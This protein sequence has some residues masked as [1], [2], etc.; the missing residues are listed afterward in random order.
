LDRSVAGKILDRHVDE[1]VLV[2]VVEQVR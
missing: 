1:L 2:V